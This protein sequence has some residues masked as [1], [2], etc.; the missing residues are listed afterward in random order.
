MTPPMTAKCQHPGPQICVTSTSASIEASL[1]RPI[2]TFDRRRIE[3]GNNP[4]PY[5]NIVS[6]G[7]AHL[8][9]HGARYFVGS[10]YLNA[11]VLCVSGAF[12]STVAMIFTFISVPV[13]TFGNTMFPRRS[14]QAVMAHRFN[15]AIRRHLS[16]TA[17]GRT[18][19]SL[20]EE[21]GLWCSMKNTISSLHPR[22][23]RSVRVFSALRSWDR[24]IS[25]R[26]RNLAA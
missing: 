5:T 19:E 13:A 16:D 20:A 9:R 10:D 22:I 8:V 4:K 24:E 12:V 21:R 7:G 11:A 2:D 23:S 1:T 25:K 15:D 17:W 26:Q 14:D 18:R 3:G 6:L